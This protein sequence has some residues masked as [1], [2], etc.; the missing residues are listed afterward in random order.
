MDISKEMMESSKVFEGIMKEWDEEESPI[1]DTYQIKVTDV[2]RIKKTAKEIKKIDH[3]AIVKYGEGMVEQL[4]AVF[5]VIRKASVG[6]VVALILVTAFL[7]AN[8]IKITIM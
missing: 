3:V 4:V 8:T 1:Q 6:V 2:K 5:D 7:I